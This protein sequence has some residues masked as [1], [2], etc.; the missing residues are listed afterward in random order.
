MTCAFNGRKKQSVLMHLE[1]PIGNLLGQRLREVL[2]VGEGYR[3]MGI[4]EQ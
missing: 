4:F 1:K 2:G 3:E